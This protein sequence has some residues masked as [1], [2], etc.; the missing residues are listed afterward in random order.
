MKQER[1]ENGTHDFSIIAF[2]GA[3]IQIWR[4]DSFCRKFNGE[5]DIFFRLRIC[6]ILH[7]QNAW[8]SDPVWNDFNFRLYFCF[9][10]TFRAKN[11]LVFWD[12][13]GFASVHVT[14]IASEI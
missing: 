2:G 12:K 14:L 7:G 11:Y 5:S 8:K 10:R 3:D 4:H 1:V 13:K 9:P 6:S